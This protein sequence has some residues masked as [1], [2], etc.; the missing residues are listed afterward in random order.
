MRKSPI[1]EQGFS[2]EL[3]PSFRFM[4]KERLKGR[5]EIR[6]VFNKGKCVTCSGAKLFLLRN[7]LSHNRIAFTFSRKFGNAVERNR[8][9]RLGREAYRHLRPRLSG[10]C[11]LILL[12][13]PD[14]AP[15]SG[16]AEPAAIPAAQAKKSG[17][18]VRTG[19][20]TF[21][22]SKAGLL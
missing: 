8:A 6:E 2:G 16:V 11:D 14:P 22:F 12:V 7:D 13:Y 10:G 19:Q 20:L 3:Q 5:D 18:A 15:V 21:L 1:K 9:R 17:F 4:R